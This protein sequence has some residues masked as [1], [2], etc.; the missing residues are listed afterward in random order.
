MDANKI[1]ETYKITGMTCAACAKAVE[2]V[3]KKLDGV[4][5]QNVN[6]ATEKLNIVYDRSKVNFDD[7]KCVIEKA[8]Y[9][10]E[11]EEENKVIELKIEGMTCAACAKAVERVGKKLEGVESISVNIATDKANVIYNPAKVKLSQIKAA[12][13]KAGYKPIGEEKKI[14]A[15]EDKLKKEKEMKTLFTKFIIATIFAI[16]LFYIAM[17]PMIPKPFGPWPLPEII[18]PMNNTLNYA[19]I[20][21]LL[22]IPVMGAGYKFYIHGFKSLFSK[23]PNMDTLVAI[24][25]SAAFLY[26][27]YTTIQI[28]NG[29]ITGM[30]H[31]QLYYESAG[32]I[33][34]LIL[35]GKYFESRS[36]GKTSE[37]IKKLMGLQPKT[38]ILIIN[39]TEVE[40]PIDEVMV[41]DIILVKPGEKIPVDGTVIEG[42]T[43]V[44]ESML[45]GE[46]IPV[47]KNVGSKVTG[48]SINKNGS[49]KFRA[50]KVGSDT[51]LAQI[52]K[53]VE[54]AQGTKAPIAK[55][56]DTVSGYFVPI[57]MTIA[58]VSALLWWIFGGKDIVFV[59]TI[60]IS[61]LVI[62]CP[63]ALGLATPTA[64]MVGTGK[65]AENGILI[66]GG[67][68]LE[69]S[70]KINTI[71]FDKT[72]TIT[73]GKPKVTDIITSEGIEEGYLLEIATSA[74]KNSE[75]PLGEAIV[76]YGMEKDINFKNLEN[77]KAIPGHGI[78][79]IIDNKK[80]LLGNRKL[81]NERNI[82]L[83]NLENKSDEL[84]REGKTPMFISINNNIGCII[85]VADVVKESSKKAIET[86]HE[87]GIKVAMVTGDNKKTASAIA[88]QV[89]I[90]IVLAEV[91]PEDKSQEVKK[92][93]EKGNF[94]AMVGDGINDAPALAKADI[95]IAIGSGT[96]V[97]MESADIVLMR[98]DLMDVPNAI[99]LSNATI[100]NI[101]QN[102]FW[103]F[104][105]NTIGIPVAAGLLYIFGGPLL[106]PM[107]AAAAMSL[108]SVSVVTNALRL[109]KFKLD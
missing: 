69:L 10:V 24:G 50:E 60:F 7:I 4:E 106:N 36:K 22:V 75:H 85:A 23:S 76:R 26:S 43:S 35:L 68:A 102:L 101:K 105:Y 45:T 11:V 8:G 3:V 37:A 12:I 100:K 104:G 64:I 71:I 57:V 59:L 74:E 56:A 77:F 84:A 92:L 5:E 95:G 25:T 21:L 6:I 29:K 14:S 54:D 2:R 44:D 13:E 73:E 65:G 108:S 61:I 27:V 89:G 1:N 55:L 42:N 49:I 39:G 72:G 51:A 90:D 109:K 80:I 53:L 82:S 30:H 9:G 98:S 33:I 87:M 41:G 103:A 91:L 66:K 83:L 40:T 62:A 15:D 107:I 20:Q 52:V 99:K 28:A 32:I 47:E 86:L 38:A 19:L 58:V 16:P 96:D 97:A 94:V 67:E 34:A 17:G 78:E 18:N 63:C 46:S 70:H 88:S 31:H 48:A 81:M 93:Q 79:V